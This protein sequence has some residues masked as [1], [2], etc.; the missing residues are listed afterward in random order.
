MQSIM[1]PSTPTT[2]RQK[3][4]D[5]LEHTSAGLDKQKPANQVSVRYLTQSLIC[6]MSNN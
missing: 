6:L 4:W 2:R 5:L 3:S 1:F